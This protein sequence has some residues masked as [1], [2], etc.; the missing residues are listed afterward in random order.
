MTFNTTLVNRRVWT[1]PVMG[2]RIDWRH[3]L[4][5]GL[6][7]C[8]LL[9][10]AGGSKLTD[11]VASG[12]VCTLE[13]TTSWVTTPYGPTIVDS[14]TTGTATNAL[15]PGISIATPANG[16]TFECAY[17]CKVQRTGTFVGILAGGAGAFGYYID[18][19]NKFNVDNTTVSSNTVVAVGVTYHVV[20]T[21][22]G[23]TFK[24]YVN[25]A[26][27]TSGTGSPG[28]TTPSVFTELLG[29]TANDPAAGNGISWMRMWNRALSAAEALALARDP[30]AMFV[31]PAERARALGVLGGSGA[32]GGP[33]TISVSD[34][35]TG[36]DTPT[37]ATIT[38][39]PSETGAGANSV[40]LATVTLA[41]ADTASGSDTNLVI[42]L[43]I[44]D[45]GVGADVA[46]LGTVSVALADSGSGSDTPTVTIQPFSVADTASGAEAVALATIAVPLSDSA[47]GAESLTATVTAPLAD[48]GAGAE[49]V[50]L[51]TVQ[52]SVTDTASGSELQ[53][54]QVT[55]SAIADTASGSDSVSVQQGGGPTTISVSD[56]ASGQ[57]VVAIGPI[58]PAVADTASGAQSVQVTVPLAISDSGAGAELV[59]AL[60]SASLTDA[61]SGTETPT[62]TIGG[63]LPADGASGSEAL[64]LG[65]VAIPLNDGASAA[66]A[67]T[68][69]VQ[70]SV[71]ESAL[72]AEAVALG[73]PILIHLT[74]SA[75]GAELQAVLV[76]L[77]TPVDTATGVDSASVLQLSV[78]PVPVGDSAHG[79]ELTQVV[80]IAF[81]GVTLIAPASGAATLVTSASGSALLA[82]PASGVAT[83]ICS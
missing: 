30:F 76:Q 58:S 18:N 75:S 27:E 32:S 21:Y 59:S 78:T 23:T 40:T 4:T 48:S 14:S 66:D 71:A 9:N 42:G 72:G 43:P 68:L 22:D 28:F 50:A 33:T 6:V 13:S 1:K 67:V 79:A 25:G 60:V 12:N 16:I 44:P 26:L 41:L 7:S 10:E 56:S 29:D 63:V 34:S 38:P 65:T 17:L 81:A 47:L 45:S 11:L 19:N 52:V 64:A 57:E 55:L 61:A 49:A 54:V 39:A 20:F 80:P 3:P 24:I 82:T 53:S 46:T 36:T 37:L 15:S 2:A 77:F 5:R 74:D 35:A 31:A 70:P 83:L 8:F 62:A 51:N 73:A 69:L